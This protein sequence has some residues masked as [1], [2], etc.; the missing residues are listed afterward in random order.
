MILIFL[1]LV[2]ILTACN[3]GGPAIIDDQ[4]PTFTPVPA[5]TPEPTASPEPTATPEPTPTSTPLAESLSTGFRIDF[6]DVGQGDATLITA[7][8][9]ETLLIDGGR[10][11]ARIRQRLQSMG[12]DDLDAIAM[13]HP[14]ADHI[15][16][17]VEVLSMYQIETIYLNGGESDSKTFATFMTDVSSENAQVLTLSRGDV[18]KLGALELQVVHPGPLSGDSNEDSMVLLLDCGEVEVLLTGDAETPSEDSMLAAG[19]LQDIDV[20]KVGHHGSRTSTSQAFL[21]ALAPEFGVISAGLNNQYDHP[22][23]EVTDRLDQAG[24]QIFMTD[25]TDGVDTV[26]LTSDCQTFQLE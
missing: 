8:T 12:I 23:T 13:T 16:G 15:A 6:I 14:D 18:I 26:V 20:L 1:L 3:S 2:G 19:V 5:A 9:G 7:D 21:D 4:V 24:V 10:S 22:H 11:K 25:T 17:L